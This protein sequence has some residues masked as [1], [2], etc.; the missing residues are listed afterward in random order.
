MRDAAQ[1]TDNQ[2]Q[3]ENHADDKPVSDAAKALRN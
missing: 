3:T 1:K 2:T